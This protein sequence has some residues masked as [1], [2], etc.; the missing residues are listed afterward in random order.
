MSGSRGDWPEVEGIMHVPFKQSIGK[1]SAMIATQTH[2][3]QDFIW[4]F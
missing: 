1:S 4:V 3:I 2:S